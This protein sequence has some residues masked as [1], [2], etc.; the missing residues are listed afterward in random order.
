[1]FGKR[2][3]EL[4]EDNDLTQKEIADKLGVGLR[5]YQKYEVEEIDPKLST[6]QYLADFYECTLD[7]IMGRTNHPK[8]G[9]A[10]F[11]MNEHKVKVGYDKKLFPNGITEEKLIE[12]KPNILKFDSDDP[13]SA[14]VTGEAVAGMVYNGNASLALQEN[15]NIAYI[16]QEGIIG[17]RT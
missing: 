3:K 6:L 4:R 13:E 9:I 10:E 15:T 17:I 5:T 8:E 16:C 14:L 11:S 2:L 7:Y 1:M 12:L